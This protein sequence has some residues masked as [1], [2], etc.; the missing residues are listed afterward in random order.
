MDNNRI[1]D[2]LTRVAGGAFSVL[3]ALGKQVQNNL[4]DK[5]DVPFGASAANDDVVRLQGMVSK[6]R[7]EQEELKKRIAELESLAGVAPK[8]AKSAP[9]AAAKST[10]KP[11]AKAKAKS[12]TK[13]KKRA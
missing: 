5:M 13:T 3:S 8:K 4:K 7:I 9:K 10:A 2:D 11:K 1:L 6:L 12:S